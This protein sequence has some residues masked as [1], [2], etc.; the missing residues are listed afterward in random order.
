MKVRFDVDRRAGKNPKVVDATYPEMEQEVLR[1]VGK[2]PDYAANSVKNLKR[3]R[4]EQKG[5]SKNITV[6]VPIS[7]RLLKL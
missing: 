1:V 6:E 3:P 4:K 2:L 7:F 5:Q